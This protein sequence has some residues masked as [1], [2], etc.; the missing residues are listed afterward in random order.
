MT[1]IMKGVKITKN[2]HWFRAF[3]FVFAVWVV[4]LN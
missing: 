1:K 2:W 3:L 4:M